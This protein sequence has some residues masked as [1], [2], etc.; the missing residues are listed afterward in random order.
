MMMYAILHRP[1]DK[2]MPEGPGRGNRGFTHCE[3]TDNRKPRLFSTSHAAYCA[4]GWWL[5]GKVKV[6]HIYDSYDGDDDERWETTSCPERN[7]EDMEIVGVELTIVR[8]DK[9]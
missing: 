2:L 9:K 3:P 8:E 4:L 1:T 5:K 7:V 6:V